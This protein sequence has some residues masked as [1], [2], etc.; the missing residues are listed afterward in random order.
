MFEGYI[1]KLSEK[2]LRILHDYEATRNDDAELTQT[3]ILVYLPEHVIQH[4]GTYF[5]SREALSFVREDHVKRVRAKIQNGNRKKG[6]AGRYLP[7]LESVRRK[8]RIRQEDW[9][10]WSLAGEFGGEVV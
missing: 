6:I 3:I 4:N 5:F 10:L 2:V 9:E 1:K 8:R 7:T